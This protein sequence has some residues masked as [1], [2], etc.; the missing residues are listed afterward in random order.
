[1]IIS[2]TFGEG[3]ISVPISGGSFHRM[4]GLA[5]D[6]PHPGENAVRA[7]LGLSA[8][9]HPHVGAKGYSVQCK[10]SHGA[11]RPAPARFPVR[12]LFSSL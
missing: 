8:G 7:P 6:R 2:E 3:I 4:P 12:N 1:M 11:G 5:G 9:P 10:C